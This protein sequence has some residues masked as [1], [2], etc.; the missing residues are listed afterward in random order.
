[1]WWPVPPYAPCSRWSTGT[2]RGTGCRSASGCSTL[3]LSGYVLRARNLLDS[4]VREAPPQA[5]PVPPTPPS[6]DVRVSRTFDGTGNDL[7]APEMGSVGSAF[8]RNLRPDLRPDLFDEPSPITVSQQLLH[9]ETFLP[10][11]SLNLLAAAWVQFQVHDWVD[12]A[13]YPL[14]QADVRVPLPPQA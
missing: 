8:G 13:R 4:E 1:M 9:R 3:R 14:G 12:H 6:E 2:C 10:A 5:R 7:S 11:R